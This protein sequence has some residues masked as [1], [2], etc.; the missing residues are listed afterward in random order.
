M[1]VLKSNFNNENCSSWIW[2]SYSDSHWILEVVEF[3]PPILSQ[4]FSQPML[5]HCSF[6]E[7]VNP[8]DDSQLFSR[9]ASVIH[10]SIVYDTGPVLDSWGRSLPCEGFYRGKSL[11]DPEQTVP[12]DGKPIK[13][14]S[15]VH[16]LC[17]ILKLVRFPR[18]LQ[19]LHCGNHNQLHGGK[20]NTALE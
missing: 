3:N 19:D 16:V 20:G 5:G 8:Q 1:Y 7:Q 6:G 11:V 9:V 14:K 4:A 18:P 2:S 17:S 10:M 13:L 12:I 15:N